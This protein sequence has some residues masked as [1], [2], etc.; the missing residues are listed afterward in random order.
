MPT[1]NVSEL[2]GGDFDRFL[3]MYC[4]RQRDEAG[5][6]MIGYYNINP[7]RRPTNELLYGNTIGATLSNMYGD[8][9]FP[10]TLLTNQPGKY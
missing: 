2:V 1:I 4:R 10:R 5:N 8:E 9:K 6:I 7:Q 3:M